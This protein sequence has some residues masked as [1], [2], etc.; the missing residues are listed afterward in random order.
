MWKITKELDIEDQFGNTIVK[1]PNIPKDQWR[2]V[3][4][5]ICEAHNNTSY[6]F[7]VLP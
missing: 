1:C 6:T 4:E 5:K 2:Q 3:A 7:E